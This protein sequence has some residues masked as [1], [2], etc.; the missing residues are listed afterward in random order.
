MLKGFKDFILRGNVVDL[1]VAVVIGA[2][3]ATIVTAFTDSIIKPLINAIT[4]ASSPGLG[5]TLI[6]GKDSTYVDFAAVITAAINFIIVAAVI[7]FVVVLPVN[8]IQ[9]RR[10]RGEETG[11]AAPTE[12]ELLAEIRDLLSAQQRPSDQPRS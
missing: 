9:E 8:V 7:Y 2:A 11:P 6:A 10:K 1:A 3:F 4:P 5:V 12:V